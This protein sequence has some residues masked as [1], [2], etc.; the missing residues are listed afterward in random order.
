MIGKQIEL[1]QSEY[2]K[3]AYT[4]QLGV[5]HDAQVVRRKVIVTIVEVRDMPSAWCAKTV[6][7]GLWIASD[8]A[9]VQYTQTLDETSMCGRFSWTDSLKGHWH[10]AQKR[11][12]I[13]PYMNPDGTKAVPQAL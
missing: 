2:V 13:L 7:G 1:W 4:D 3:H 12:F 9:G 5:Q 6:E 8:E 10:A 11:G